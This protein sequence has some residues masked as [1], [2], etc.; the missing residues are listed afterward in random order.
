MRVVIEYKAFLMSPLEWT[1]PPV[2]LAV[3]PP[4][5]F[6]QRS[7]TKRKTKGA[8]SQ[9]IAFVRPDLSNTATYS[10]PSKSLSLSHSNAPLKYIF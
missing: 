7:Y 8:S 10:V 2:S 6:V 1:K 4:K 3:Y 5:K 9:N